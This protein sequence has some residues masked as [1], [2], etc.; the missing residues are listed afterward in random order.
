MQQPSRQQ[1]LTGRRGLERTG[2]DGPMNNHLPLSLLFLALC[3][4][5]VPLSAALL[6][7]GHANFS[8]VLHN[9]FG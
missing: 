2:N 9:A 4:A 6:M 1:L 8:A 7:H 5:V 3:L